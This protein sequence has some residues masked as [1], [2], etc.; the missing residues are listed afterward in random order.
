MALHR[1]DFH[2]RYSTIERQGRTQNN[3]YSIWKVP[4][5]K[6]TCCARP[7]PTDPRYFAY[8]F[9]CSAESFQRVQRLK[10]VLKYHGKYPGG[11]PRRS[12][13]CISTASHGCQKK[14][15]T[16]A[17]ESDSPAYGTELITIT[18]SI[19]IDF[20][21]LLLQTHVLIHDQKLRVLHGI[22]NLI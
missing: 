14:G 11:N 18:E 16:R 22:N 17:S 4:S 3:S 15:K 10:G 6:T 13:P 20:D 12:T 2:P 21:H 8:L 1:R 19:F 7:V 5:E 9:F